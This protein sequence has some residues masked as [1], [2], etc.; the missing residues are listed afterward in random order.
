MLPLHQSGPC[1]GLTCGTR[2]NSATKVDARATQRRGRSG[3]ARVGGAAG[4][5]G[6]AH[7]WSARRD[8]CRRIHELRGTCLPGCAQRPRSPRGTCP[9]LEPSNGHNANMP[10]PGPGRG[11]CPAEIQPYKGHVQCWP[12][13]P[14]MCRRIHALRGTCLPGHAQRPWSLCGICPVLVPDNGH[15]AN[16]PIPGPRRG[17]C[18]AGF[19]PSK[20][21]VQCWPAARDM[22]C[23]ICALQGTCPMLVR[24]VGHALRDLSPPRD[25]S[26]VGP[27]RGTCPVGFEGCEGHVQRWVLTLGM[28]RGGQEATPPALPRLRAIR[29]QGLRVPR[30]VPG[31]SR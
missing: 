9:A 22:P 12:A 18:P 15:N 10:I 21:H 28:S 19:E 7:S 25:M 26:G 29:V 1:P 24:A 20:G 30:P 23:G 31:V 14:D 3:Q 5:T 13:R 8:M 2:I 11:A 16:M 27:R 17:T 4:A 6:H